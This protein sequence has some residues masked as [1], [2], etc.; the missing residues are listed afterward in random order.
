MRLSV[1][2]TAASVPRRR[3]GL[4]KVASQRTGGVV[5][6]RCQ[7]HRA[8]AF[9]QKPKLIQML[10]NRE[11]TAVVL[12]LPNVLVFREARGRWIVNIPAALSRTNLTD[13]KQSLFG[14]PGR[15]QIGAKSDHRRGAIA[16]LEQSNGHHHVHRQVDFRQKT[17]VCTLNLA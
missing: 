3:D 7:P 4:R 16:L 14:G 12:E 5:L 13:F 17:R 8:S 11:V 6:Q 15:I 10:S 9:Q 1:R 2:D